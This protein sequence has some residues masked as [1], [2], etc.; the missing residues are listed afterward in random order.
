M[1]VKQNNS[2]FTIIE[3]LI[4]TA[5]FSTVLLIASTVII[6]IG[7]LYYKGLISAQTQET[8]RN[9]AE[10]VSQDL[11]FSN[12]NSF[13]QDYTDSSVTG[14]SA[15]QA[16]TAPTNHAYSVCAGNN[17]Y[18]YWLGQPVADGNHGIL[19]DDAPEGA[20]PPNGS[21]K[22]LL[23]QNMRLTEFRVVKSTAD[24]NLYN[25]SIKV[26]YGDSDLLTTYNQ[27]TGDL[28]GSL[29]DT[30][31]RSGIAGSNFCA[32]STLDTTVKRRLN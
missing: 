10:N 9:I 5:V 16:P 21:G 11:K 28:E 32:T 3:L 29:P 14:D 8:V 7:R 31:C 6:Q 4:A 26:A 17:R 25:I 19:V 20:C 2:G 13:R 12:G 22:E 30:L 15:T 18:T 1:S 27:Q 23:G 24:P